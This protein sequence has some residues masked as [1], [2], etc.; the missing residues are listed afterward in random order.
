MTCKDCIQYA[1]CKDTA[2]ESG[3]EYYTYDDD[4]YCEAFARTCVNFS[5]K[6]NGN[7]CRKKHMRKGKTHED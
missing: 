2:F 6:L 3:G 5:D 4:G 1:A 7:M